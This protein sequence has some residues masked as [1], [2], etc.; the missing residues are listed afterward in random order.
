MSKEISSRRNIFTNSD[1]SRDIINVQFFRRHF[2]RVVKLNVASFVTTV[3][4]GKISFPTLYTDD[5]EPYSLLARRNV[6]ATKSIKILS[7]DI[8]IS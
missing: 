1:E 2:D 3:E 4:A 6:A 7:F 5:N 8:L